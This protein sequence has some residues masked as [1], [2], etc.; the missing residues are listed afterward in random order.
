MES[1]SFT[2]FRLKGARFFTYALRIPFYLSLKSSPFPK[3]ASQAAAQCGMSSSLSFKKPTVCQE[4][5]AAS[6]RMREISE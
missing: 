2:A 1:F 4:I 6:R 3:M 5:Q